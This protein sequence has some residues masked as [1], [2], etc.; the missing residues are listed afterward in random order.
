MQSVILPIFTQAAACLSHGR[1]WNWPSNNF[2]SS[3]QITG[4]RGTVQCPQ[5]QHGNS[6]AAKFC[7]ECGTRLVRVCPDCGHEVSPRA[8]F[9]PE[10]GMPLTDKEP[11]G[12]RSG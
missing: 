2:A 7:E 12:R 10:C 11:E 4:G 1:L 3:D 8:K 5:C 9:C 6:V